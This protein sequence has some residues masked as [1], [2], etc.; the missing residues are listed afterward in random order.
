MKV[1]QSVLASVVL[2]AASPGLASSSIEAVTDGVSWNA[3]MSNGRTAN[4]T[5]NPDGSGRMN[6]GI[7]S[8]NITWAAQGG[9][10][11]LSG[12]PRRQGPNCMT[13]VAV[14]G[15]YQLTSDEGEVLTLSR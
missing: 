2:L 1:I 8:R 6:A 10:I 3:S 15:G 4:L 14:Q 9:K 11:C 7:M 13:P 5:L 12:L